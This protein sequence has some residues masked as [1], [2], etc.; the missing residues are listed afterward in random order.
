MNIHVSVF[1]NIHTRELLGGVMAIFGGDANQINFIKH[2]QTC[3][4]QLNRNHS[5]IYN[6]L[7]RQ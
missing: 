7:N 1:R 6:S 3:M 4:Y 5:K 2:H